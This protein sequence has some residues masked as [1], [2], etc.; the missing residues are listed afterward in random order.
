MKTVEDYL[1]EKN[2]KFAFL[3]ADTTDIKKKE[4]YDNEMVTFVSKKKNK[5]K[6]NLKK[7]M[8]KMI[9][10]TNNIL[11]AETQYQRRS[12]KNNKRKNKMRLNKQEFPAL[13]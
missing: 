10:T 8:D 12:Y 9:S 13:E 5:R 7:N 11:S 6:L 4:T 1:A 2:K 3:E